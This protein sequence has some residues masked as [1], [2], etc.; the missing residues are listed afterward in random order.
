M[1]LKNYE[2]RLVRVV[3]IQ[4]LL[5]FLLGFDTLWMTRESGLT[6]DNNPVSADDS[7]HLATINQGAKNQGLIV[8]PTVAMVSHQKG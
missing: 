7:I 8:T 3:G 2:L 1:L 5:F 4:I 6:F